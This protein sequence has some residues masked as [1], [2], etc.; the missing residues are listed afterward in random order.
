MERGCWWARPEE[1]ARQQAWPFWIFLPPSSLVLFCT[2]LPF[3]AHSL[4]VTL[5]YY[6]YFWDFHGMARGA[7][8]GI[9]RRT[10]LVVEVVT[11]PEMVTVRTD[12]VEPKLPSQ[13]HMTASETPTLTRTPSL[14]RHHLSSACSPLFCCSLQAVRLPQ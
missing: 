9:E 11:W 7:G 14:G 4:T 12:V 10:G 2:V 5:Q 13:S 1:E 6:W 3:H 8:L